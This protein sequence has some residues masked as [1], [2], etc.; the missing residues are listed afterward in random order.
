VLVS[1]RRFRRQRRQDARRQ[2]PQGEEY[3]IEKAELEAQKERDQFKASL[4]EKAGH[5]HYPYLKDPFD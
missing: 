3:D 4:F 5:A 1:L 2:H